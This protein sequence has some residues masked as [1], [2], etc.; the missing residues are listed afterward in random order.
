MDRPSGSGTRLGFDSESGQTK[1]FKIDIHSFLSGRS[2][3][4][5]QCGEQADKFTCCAVEK[6]T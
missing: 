5:G 4:K 3:L 6:G 1:D 2:A